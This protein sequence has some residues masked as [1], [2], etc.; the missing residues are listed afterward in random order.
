M[1]QHDF[2]FATEGEVRMQE[3]IE[4]ALNTDIFNLKLYKP[5]TNYHVII[6]VYNLNIEEIRAWIGLPGNHVSLEIASREARNEYLSRYIKSTCDDG[7]VIDCD[8]AKAIFTRR[9][10]RTGILTSRTGHQLTLNRLMASY[11]H[12]VGMGI[13]EIAIPMPHMQYHQAFDDYKDPINH[14]D[15]IGINSLK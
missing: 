15:N 14:L 8:S 13:A 7:T 5:H 3:I 12:N 9:L 6:A 11:I 1:Q 4:Y 10:A 2:L